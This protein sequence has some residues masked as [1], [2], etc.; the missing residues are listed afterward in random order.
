M[1][2]KHDLQRRTPRWCWLVM[3]AM[4]FLIL[5]GRGLVI[6]QNASPP[7][8]DASMAGAVLASTTIVGRVLDPSGTPA[9]DVAVS[10]LVR[11]P[12][13]D[14]RPGPAYV[15]AQGRT[16]AQG[17]FRLMG[18]SVSLPQDLVLTVVAYRPGSAVAWKQ[19][20]IASGTQEATLQFEAEQPVELQAVDGDGKPAVGVKIAVQS[21]ARNSGEQHLPHQWTAVVFP[22][23]ASASTPDLAITDAQGR[24][25]LHGIHRGDLVGIQCNDSRF[26]PE[27]RDELQTTDGRATL[28][29]APPQ[30]LEGTVHL[31][32]GGDT[33]AGALVKAI[34]WHSTVPPGGYMYSGAVEVRTDANGEFRVIP[35]HA[36]FLSIIVTAPQN[37]TFELM[38]WK[39][40]KKILASKQKLL[41]PQGTVVEGTVIEAATGKPIAG[42]SVFYESPRHKPSLTEATSG[43]D[44]RFVLTAGPGH[45]ALLVRAPTPDYIK[46]DTTSGQAI[47]SYDRPSGIHLHPDGLALLDLKPDTKRQQI[48]I[49]LRRG[50]TIQGRAVDPDGTPVVVGKVITTAYAPYNLNFSQ[51][52]DLPIRNG[53]FMIPG[54]DPDK[55]Y[56]IYLVDPAKQCGATVMLSAKA[57]QPVEINLDACGSATAQLV[58]P[59][60]RPYSNYKTD[61]QPYISISL[62]EAP[63]SSETGVIDGKEIE[64]EEYLM[65]NADPDRYQALRADA[66]GRITFP[67]LIPGADYR[68]MALNQRKSGDGKKDFTVQPGQAA[69]LGKI[70]AER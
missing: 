53:Q 68:L 48:T 14:Q 49:K 1:K 42:A 50:V 6:G 20:V 59:T 21:I 57:A 28:I 22:Q 26:A 70:T 69:N 56:R 67:T 23:D 3:A 60:N 17:G 66:D 46:Q 39:D 61:E 24:I 15:L 2:R 37:G 52:E 41:V 58:D 51:T 35:Y 19:L 63:G 7:A 25:A 31:Q 34:S 43:E 55:E 47:Y 29:L 54:L 4:A 18:R 9:A 27:S 10:A 65:E 16:D 32:D 13:R 11:S 40:A 12:T 64:F 62:I 36:E 45:G 38:K 33:V 30:P 8:G 44:G 5:P